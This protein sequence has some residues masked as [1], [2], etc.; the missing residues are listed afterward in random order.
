MKLLSTIYKIFFIG[1]I[2]LNTG[3]KKAKEAVQANIIE[4]FYEQ[5]VLNKDFIISYANNG[6]EEITAQYDGYKFRLVKNSFYDGPLTATKDGITYTGSWSATQDYGKLTISMP[7]SPISEFSF[8]NREWRFI[9][10]ALPTMKLSPWI[11]TDTDA[12]EL[13]ITR[14]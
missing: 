7:L 9:E 5:N 11:R 13:H 8:L 3:C 2:I 14:L 1:I 10:K 4:Q 6:K 12:T